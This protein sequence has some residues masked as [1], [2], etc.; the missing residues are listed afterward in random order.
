MRKCSLF[1]LFVLTTFVVFSQTKSYNTQRITGELPLI[2]GFFEEAAWESVPWAGDFTQFEPQNGEKASEKTEFKILYTD[3][4]LYMAVKAYDSEADKIERRMS[5]RDGWEGDAIGLQLDSYDDKRTAFVFAVS[6]A[7]VKT[8]GIMTNDNSDNFDDSWDPI[9]TV[10][11]RI[12]A[13]GWTAEIKIPLTQLRFAKK[14]KQ[15]W[16]LEVIRYI[17]RKNEFSLWQH[18]SDD[19]SGWVHN[20]GKLQGLNNLTPQFEATLSPYTV[21]KAERYEEEEGNPYQTGSSKKVSFG[22]DGKVGLTSDL[23]LDF[24]INPDFG[25][26]EADP[27]EVN[28][29]AFETFF[30][31]KRPFFIEGKNITNF[32]ITDGG[33]GFGRD[34]LFYSRRIGRSPRHYPNTQGDEYVDI[35]SN[36]TILES[37]KLTGK[38]KNGWSIGLIESFTAAGNAEIDNQ[39]EKR[40]EEV[41]PFTNYFIGSLQ[42]DMNEGNTIMGAMITSTNRK[43]KNE[44]IDFLHDNAYTMGLSFLQYFK[45]KKYSLSG[46]LAYSYVEGDSATILNDQNSHL[47]YFQRPDAEYL[48]MDSTLTSLNG[49]G[50]TIKFDR[51]GSSKL[52]YM[53]SLTW[54]TPGFDLNDVGY[55]RSADRIMFMA[56]AGYRIT[57]PFSIFRSANFSLAEW[58]GWDFGGTNIFNG[59]NL[60]INLQFKNQWNIGGGIN[61]DLENVDNQKLRGGTSILIPGGISNWAFISTDNRKKLKLSTGMS[62]YQGK[63]S[64]S[65]NFWASLSYRPNNR[66]RLSLNPSINFNRTQLQYVG[67]ET[68]YYNDETNYLFASIQQKTFALTLRIDLSITPDLSIQY[69]GQAFVSAG[70]YSDFKKITDPHADVYEDRFHVFTENEIQYNSDDEVYKVFDNPAA[71]DS[72]YSISSPDF[73][74]KQFHSN[75]VVRWEYLPSSVLYLVWSQS[76]TGFSN[77]GDFALQQNYVDLFSVEPHDVFLLKF[78]YLFQL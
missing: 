20:F 28:L 72:Y 5:R 57:K 30:Q 8:D 9:W 32:N 45:D 23:T 52:R 39:G 42:K 61:F 71:P 4:Y 66:L 60:N 22:V 65:S 37:F 40:Y 54:R 58:S 55:L 13:D 12:T 64:Q 10:K 25:Q 62:G 6:A 2:D 41:E 67:T 14:D 19:E 47:R 53:T 29:T 33:G 24:T 76:R 59:G 49:T 43:N 63:N 15:I 34:N 18:V 38:T 78:S 70:K 35:P 26:V 3:T 50:G 77:E 46:K 51:L 48:S 56:W 17:F 1:F 31:E 44:N 68:T 11:T 16:G 27:S 73:N 36:T 69:Y 75:L 21:A 7:G 74:F